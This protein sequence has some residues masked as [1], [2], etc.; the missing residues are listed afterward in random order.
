MALRSAV[1]RGSEAWLFAGCGVVAD[2]DPAL[3]L[4]ETLLK[5]RPMELALAAALAADDGAEAV[6]PDGGR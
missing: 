2:S 1:I 5:L 6:G 4:G 3:E